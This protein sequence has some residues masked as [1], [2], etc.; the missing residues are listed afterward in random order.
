MKKEKRKIL[1]P[2]TPKSSKH[3]DIQVFILIYF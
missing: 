1:D 3:E 2:K